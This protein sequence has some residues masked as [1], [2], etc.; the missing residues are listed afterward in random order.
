MNI[1]EYQARALL[2]AAGVPMLDG[3]VA[4]TPTGAEAIARRIGAP[5]VR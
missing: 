5:E 3:D 1:H 4:S 2:K